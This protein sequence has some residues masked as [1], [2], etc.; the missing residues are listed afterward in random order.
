MKLS[1]EKPV[2]GSVLVP[3]SE[4]EFESLKSTDQG[5]FYLASPYSKWEDKE[6]ACNRVSE[7][8]A[9]LH[10]EGLCCISPIA[11][12]HQATKFG[13]EG[14]WEDWKRLDTALIVNPMCLGIIVAKFDGWE[15]SV[16]V[17]E[18]II[19]ARNNK[20]PVFYMEVE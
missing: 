4:K 14:K 9:K 20:K 5:Y 2:F 1:F 19:I 7:V 8:W 11:G 16:G 12:S 18:E 17:Q 13:A 6:D 10:N 15:E 3:V